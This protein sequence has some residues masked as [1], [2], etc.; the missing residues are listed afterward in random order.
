MTDSS[1]ISLVKSIKDGQNAVVTVKTRGNETV[2]L[3]C[4]Y[5]ESIAPNFFIALTR[6]QF[7]EDIQKSAPVTL[8]LLD[9]SAEKF[10]LTAR[11]T[12]QLNKRT[13]ELTAAKSIDPSSMR[14]YFRVDFRTDITL[15]HNAG[16]KPDNSHRSAVK[17][18][19]ID[20][21]ASGVLGIFPEDYKKISNINIEIKLVQP[22]KTIDCIGHVVRTRRTRSGKVLVALHFDHISNESR[23]ALI[24]NCL[25]EQRRQ[26]RENIQ[27]TG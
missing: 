14:E 12:E 13:I 10:V 8:A 15:T 1:L 26:L 6:G 27:T 9:Q 2:E 7:P 22:N 5:K 18:Q 17:G 20:L 4:V 23:D 25:G 19:T 3:E 11:V 16:S 21:S 24:K